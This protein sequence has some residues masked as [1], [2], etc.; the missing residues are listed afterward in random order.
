MSTFDSNTA[1][2]PELQS[3]Y[4]L[5]PEQVA[6][7]QRDG[8]IVLPQVITGE[9]MAAY[10]PMIHAAVQEKL[11][12]E[13]RDTS[14]PVEERDTVGKA[15]LQVLHLWEN[16]AP[17]RTF[18]LSKRL[19]KIAAQLLE[20]PAVRFYHDQ[21][22]FK[23]AGGGHTP[24]HQDGYY[25]PL[26]TDRV[27]T[28]WIPLVDVTPEMGTMN[29]VPGSHR[30]G[31]L[32]DVPT[33]DASEARYQQLIAERGWQVSSTGAMQA[34]D[35]AIHNR[36]TLHNAGSNETSRTREAAVLLY[37]P[38]GAR[39]LAENSPIVEDAGRHHLG[40]RKAGELADSVINPIVYP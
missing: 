6:A 22:L 38:D 23:E 1:K 27:L 15:F 36:W 9:E 18:S 10:R 3:E 33:S 29:Y 12:A 14:R 31:G 7:F 32:L 8:Y 34:G 21:V 28:M 20:V 19:A 17:M 24:W 35:V 39:L 2:L 11:R 26:D 40:G 13:G 4:S 16:Y 37:Y 25:I 5:R 30:E